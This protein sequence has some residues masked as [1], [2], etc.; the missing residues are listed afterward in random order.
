MN[1]AIENPRPAGE[2]RGRKVWG[3]LIKFGVPLVVSIGLC[4]LLFKGQNVGDMMA[5]IRTQ[6]DFRWI[7]LCLSLAIF[8]H[9]IR[10][11]RWGIQLRALGIKVPLYALVLSIFGC[12]AVNLVLPR[13]GELWRSGYIARRQNVAFDRV[14][15]SMIADRLSDTI[16][17]GLLTLVTF[18]FA[19]NAMLDYLGQNRDTYHRLADLMT[20][21]WLW[22]GI[23]GAVVVMA[24]LLHAFR[25][26]RFV[27]KLADFCRG[28]WQGFAVIA[29]MPGKGRWLLLTV[30]LWSCYFIQLY[31]AFYS[32]P[33]TAE[34]VDVHGV[35][36]VFVCWVLSSL[37]MGVPSNGGI[38]PWQWAVVFGLGIYSAGVP[39][40]TTQYATTFANLVMGTNTLLL[41][42]LGLFTFAC[43]AI[44]RRREP[45]APA[46]PEPTKSD[47]HV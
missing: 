8:S 19:G 40:L 27:K 35:T 37:S 43:I 36:A 11:M 4:Y 29:T 45:S 39:G 34:V 32:L 16:V 3:A 42:A 38:G 10:A 9:V 1:S 5:V 15:G 12:Y 20:S 44:E 25:R 47:G 41:I 30:L 21:P 31:V 7:L 28:I 18:V 14:F 24:L 17:V 33:L 26:T 13:L 6:C 46:A 2:S 22:A 23:A